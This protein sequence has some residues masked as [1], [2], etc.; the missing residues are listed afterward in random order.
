MWK[1]Y[2]SPSTLGE[3]LEL[4]AKPGAKIIAGATDLML[5]L[6]AGG[7]PGLET[8]VDVTRIPDLDQISLDERGWLHLGPLVSHNDC[9][10]SDLVIGQA[11]ALAQACWQVG[12]PQ[13]RTRGTIAGNLVTASPAND[14]IPPLMALGAELTLRSVRGERRTR[15]EDFYTGVRMR[16]LEPDE[17]L[18]DIAFPAIGAEG[19]SAFYKLGLRRS[20]AI[21]LV[22]AA[23]VLWFEGS[24]IASAALTLGAVAPTIVHASEAEEY[25]VGKE[26]TEQVISTAGELAARAARP[27]DDVRASADY[28]RAMAR[29][30]AMRSLR[31]L[32]DATERK[33]YPRRRV[34]LEERNRALKP[35]KETTHLGP[36]GRIETTV[37]GQHYSV[38]G[39]VGKTLLQMLREDLLLTGSKEGCGEGE[40]GACTVILDGQ[41]V[42][43][44]LVPAARAHGAEIRTV[45]GVEREGE[46]HPLQQAFI[47]QGAVQCGFC[48]PGFVMSAV[49]LLD[50]VEQPTLDE[51]KIAVAGNLCRCTGYYKI[52]SAIQEAAERGG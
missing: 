4:L 36:G 52:L 14:S 17:M 26:L 42:M 27:I 48:T 1:D 45:E 39:S 50:E 35:L 29:L 47:E 49:M 28:R 21:S 46:L 31:P 18:V 10:N 9:A 15:L 30:C 8:L 20:H 40:C 25:L 38:E 51:I 11:F 24:V 12:T 13:I 23:A 2:L 34:L 5:E 22:N 32:A 7:H 33:Q 19:R 41:A 3:A 43:A 16:Q 44:C 37:N 6:E